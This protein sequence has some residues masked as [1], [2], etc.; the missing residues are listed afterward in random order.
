MQLSDQVQREMTVLFCDIRNFTTFAEKLSPA[1]VFKFINL[2]LGYMVPVIKKRQGFVDKYIGDAIMALFEQPTDAVRVGLEM[3]ERL[4]AFNKES[5]YPPINIGIGI[6]TGDLM[7]GI[8]GDQ[9]RIE[10]SVLGDTVN[11]AS[12]IESL[13]KQYPERLLISDATKIQLQPG[14]FNLHKVGDVSVKG[15][16]HLVSIWGVEES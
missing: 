7:L 5:I 4:E 12:R 14:A 3:L 15:K 16:S 2:F 13:T 1:E 6:N 10:G 9:S 8:I 11:I